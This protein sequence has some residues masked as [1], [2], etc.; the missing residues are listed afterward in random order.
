M[1]SEGGGG[2]GTL[3][4]V[5]E[6]RGE[7]IDVIIPMTKHRSTR[8]APAECVIGRLMDLFDKDVHDL[9]DRER[10]S[11]RAVLHELLLSYSF[12]HSQWIQVAS[13]LVVNAYKGDQRSP[14]ASAGAACEFRKMLD[15]FHVD[16]HLSFRLDQEDKEGE[17]FDA[18]RDLWDELPP[19]TRAEAIGMLGELVFSLYQKDPRLQGQPSIA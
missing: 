12:S 13:V 9:T 18:A 7:G 19:L 6:K 11:S 10:Q 15:L 5:L 17:L 8:R 4:L 1:W 14:A 3:G 16:I 2:T